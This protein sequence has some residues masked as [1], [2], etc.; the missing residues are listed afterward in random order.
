MSFDGQTSLIGP[1]NRMH[2]GL[3]R[4][5]GGVLDGDGD[6]ADVEETDEELLV[7][8]GKLEV[9]TE[10]EATVLRLAVLHFPVALLRDLRIAVVCQ[11]VVSPLALL[12][13]N[14]IK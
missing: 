6:S 13:T 4:Q 1:G 9:V 5:V 14:R 8:T 10:G 2:P 3:E 11:S 7:V 12:L